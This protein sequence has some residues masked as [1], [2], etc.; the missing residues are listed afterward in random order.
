[1]SKNNV[2]FR[3]DYV[4]SF[5]RPDYL[6]KARADFEKRNITKEELTEVENKA[7][8]DLVK[9]QKELGYKVITDGEFRRATWHLDFM[10]GFNGVAHK[11]TEKGVAFHGE[12]ALIDDTWL[13]GKISVDNHPFVEHYK[14]IKTFEDENTVAKQT[15]P[16]PAQ[17]FQQ[18]IIPANIETTRKCTLYLNKSITFIKRLLTIYIT[19]VAETFSLT[20]APGVYSLPR[21]V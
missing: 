10:W 17:F 7:I 21:A 12:P 11:K 18:M 16:A 2:P 1:M 3:F 20:I 9:K 15:I 13:T 19:Q 5:L 6:K 8:T 14:F 4:G